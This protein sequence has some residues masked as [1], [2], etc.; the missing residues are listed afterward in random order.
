MTRSAR[1]C[2]PS[3]VSLLALGVV[4]C[5]AG[6]AS[7]ERLDVLG[8]E[9]R[10]ELAQR[11]YTQSVRWGE[12]ERASAFVAEDARAEFLAHAPRL[13]EIHFTDYARGKLDVDEQLR[14]ATITVTYHG[15]APASLVE[16]SGSETQVWEREENATSWTV[17]PDLAG[18]EELMAATTFPAV[19]ARR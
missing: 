9:S 15:Y 11:Q 8:N 6:C 17:R 19:D 2:R 13:R 1:P 5:L 12:I 18:L 10:L 16:L 14:R 7:L 4:A 3:L